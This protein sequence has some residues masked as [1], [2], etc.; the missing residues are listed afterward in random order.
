MTSDEIKKVREAATLLLRW[1]VGGIEPEAVKL[2]CGFA[3]SLVGDDGE[4][5][6][7]EDWLE[8]EY[9]FKYSDDDDAWCIDVDEMKYEMHKQRNNVWSLYWDELESWPH[10]IHCRYEIRLLAAVLGI[11]K[12]GE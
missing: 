4:L 7:T 9:G 2:V 12:K 1:H 5:P 10:D 6:V 11:P 8:K 3:H